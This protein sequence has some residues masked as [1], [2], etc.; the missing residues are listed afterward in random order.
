MCKL[1]TRGKCA[2]LVSAIFSGCI[3]DAKL[4]VLV[5]DLKAISADRVEKVI[6]EDASLPIMSECVDGDFRV[7]TI[8]TNLNL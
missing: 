5:V 2:C 4:D 3:P 7:L 6:G 1:S 8:Q